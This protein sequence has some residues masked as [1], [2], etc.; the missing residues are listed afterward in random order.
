MPYIL[1]VQRFNPMGHIEHPEWKGKSEHVGYMNKIFR[2]KNEAADFYDVHNPHMRKLNTFNTWCSDWDA[3][4][5][6]FYVV[7]KHTNEYLK[8]PSTFVHS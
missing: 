7:R 3:N 5:R 8:L 1:E 4:T 6:L 2:T